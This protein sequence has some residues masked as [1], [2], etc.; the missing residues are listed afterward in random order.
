MKIRA[1][2]AIF[3]PRQTEFSFVFKLI[4]VNFTPSSFDHFK[5]RMLKWFCFLLKTICA[6]SNKSVSIQS[7]QYSFIILKSKIHFNS[8]ELACTSFNQHHRKFG[9]YVFIFTRANEILDGPEVTNIYI[10]VDSFKNSA[11]LLFKTAINQ[12]KW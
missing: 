5:R 7:S 8:N 9:T 6:Y 2:R 10:L 11:F 4:E 1:Y 12:T 3:I